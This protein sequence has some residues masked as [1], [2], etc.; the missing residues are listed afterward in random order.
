MIEVPLCSYFRSSKSE[1]VY[2]KSYDVCSLTQS[3]IQIPS[4]SGEEESLALYIKEV[5]SDAGVDTVYIDSY[6]NVIT[7]IDGSGTHTVMFEGHMDHVPPG[8][9]TLWKDFPYSGRV[10]EGIIYGR[11]AVDMKG[12]LAAMISS[13]QTLSEG[14]RSINLIGAFVVHE[15]T[16]EGAA[17]QRIVEEESIHPDLVILGEPTGLHIALGHRGR[18]LI[19]VRLTGKTAH[20]SMPDLGIN[21]IESGTDFIHT[22]HQSSSLLPTDPVLGKA[23][24][25]PIDI[26][27]NPQG[28]PQL[29]DSCELLFDRRLIL[30]EQESHLIGQMEEIINKLQK[31][32]RVH[33]GTVS[34]Q[35]EELQCWT[36]ASLQVKDF[37]PAWVTPQSSREVSILKK[38]LNHLQPRLIYWEFSTDG[39]YTASKASIPTIGF[40]PG[41]WRC[42]H[43][44]DEQVAIREL[45][46]ATQG[47]ASIVHHLE[48]EF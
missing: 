26:T 3:L 13:L 32:S 46:D 27:C 33:S 5:L 10:S 16:V 44:P 15:E 35:E 23:T 37:F 28:L 24:I 40:G 14:E 38:A 21:S 39:V 4:V 42:A 45:K 47:Y 9:E 19:K 34:I 7:R 20:A 36:G 1:G 17:I 30:H 2:M 41:D 25:T 11:G 29:P 18:A 48:D 6:G 22:L 8:N 31:E 12:S 43:Q